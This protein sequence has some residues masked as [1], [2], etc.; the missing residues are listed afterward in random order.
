MSLDFFQR[1]S[2]LTQVV[3]NVIACSA[4]ALSALSVKRW[5]SSVV[6]QYDVVPWE[7]SIHLAFTFTHGSRYS[8]SAIVPSL[9]SSLSLSTQ[10]PNWE[11]LK[12]IA[13]DKFH[14][15][16]NLSSGNQSS[17]IL[18]PQ[19]LVREILLHKV[20]NSPYLRLVE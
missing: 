17:E 2:G 5:H 1:S 6:A 11:S 20:N 9:G 18:I 16:S 12:V 15:N 10:V 8:S 3:R 7:K 19:P 4:A 14:V 13:L